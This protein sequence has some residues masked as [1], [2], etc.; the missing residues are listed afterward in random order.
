[1]TT[2]QDTKNN[3]TE[4]D[5]KKLRIEVRKRLI[6]WFKK[7]I[8]YNECIQELLNKLSSSALN[9]NDCNNDGNKAINS[10]DRC[11]LRDEHYVIL[12]DF[13]KDYK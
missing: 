12:R 9:F 5:K 6:K 7:R 10:F 3:L 2:T 4:D 8:V 13:I 11:I 1:M